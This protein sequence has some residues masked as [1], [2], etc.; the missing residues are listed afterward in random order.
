MEHQFSKRNRLSGQ[1]Q[2]AGKYANF[3]SLIRVFNITFYSAISPYW[4]H[5]NS[6][7][8]REEPCSPKPNSSTNYRKLSDETENMETSGS[9]SPLKDDKKCK[10]SETDECSYTETIDDRYKCQENNKS[11]KHSK[12]GIEAMSQNTD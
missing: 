1:I 9:R 4:Y 11:E 2:K 10:Y 8:R 5:I 6:R 3:R 7:F 12:T